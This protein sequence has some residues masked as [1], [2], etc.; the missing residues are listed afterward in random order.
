MEEVK[1]D[2]IIS[3]LKEKL[4]ELERENKALLKIISHDIKSPFNKLHALVNLI[5]MD[6]E[7]LDEE[8][9]KLLESMAMV[10]REGRDMINN[11]LDLRA[12]EDYEVKPKRNDLELSD[13]IQRSVGG[14]KA[15]AGRKDIK[16]D[17]D[18]KKN[19]VYSDAYFLFRIFDHLI[20]N[21]IKYGKKQSVIT[22]SSKKLE[23]EIIISVRNEGVPI[24]KNEWGNLFKKFKVLGTK[25]TFGEHSSGL[26][27]Y[28]AQALTEKLNGKIEYHPAK[29]GS[30][31]ILKLPLW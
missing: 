6:E 11:L 31:F 3:G 4:I 18:C 16:I 13:I 26:G 19:H 28:L 1:N 2:K 20:S 23:K 21:A 22:I 24:P 8:R 29:T 14:M 17:Y 15:L 12:L 25:T 30:V 9:N 7:P 27:L 5:Q 10:I